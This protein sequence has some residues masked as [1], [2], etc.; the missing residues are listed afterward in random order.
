MLN[1]NASD[2]QTKF[3][4]ESQSMV[5]AN[6]QLGVVRGGD[7]W[8]IVEAMESGWGGES[9]DVSMTIVTMFKISLELFGFAWIDLGFGLDLLGSSLDLLGLS[10]D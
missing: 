5:S 10:L 1:K 3:A 6:E 9:H 4:P 8:L 2:L 7:S